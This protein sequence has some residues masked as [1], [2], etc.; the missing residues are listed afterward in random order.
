MK[1]GSAHSGETTRRTRA[2]R[3]VFTTGEDPALKRLNLVGAIDQMCETSDPLIH[4]TD[5]P[6]RLSSFYEE[7]LVHKEE[8]P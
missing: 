4:F 7:K 6:L 8:V 2:L 3:P 5:W 1:L